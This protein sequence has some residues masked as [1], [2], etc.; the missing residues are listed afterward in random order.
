M[1]DKPRSEPEY[2]MERDMKRILSMVLVAALLVATGMLSATSAPA[3]KSMAGSYQGTAVGY[4]GNIQVTV[5]LDEKGKIL[6][7]KVADGHHETKGVGTV[8]IKKLSKSIVEKQALDVDGVTGATLTGNAVRAAV[9]DAL[10]RAGLDPKAMG[11]VPVVRKPQRKVPFNPAAMPKKVPKTGSVTIKDAKGR[12]VT[13]GLPVSSYAIS[14]MD[15]IDYVIPILGK[16]AFNKL[17]ASG[18]SG[19][20]SIGKYSRLYSPIVGNYLEHFGQISEHNAPFDLE[21]ILA[22]NPDVLIVNSA[23]AAHRH[24]GAIKDQL[25][26]VGI[27]IVMIDVPGKSM[28]TSAQQTL[29]DS[30]QDIPKGSARRRGDRFFG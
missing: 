2:N 28:T 17:V 10:K 1:G 25:K 22:R 5:E 3:A 20:R 12:K 11:Y 15:V 19:S 30:G 27:P 29:R 4:H 8:P 6:S 18:Q 23:M 16:D 9:A 24:A 26:E 7:V 14:T 21:M 13:I